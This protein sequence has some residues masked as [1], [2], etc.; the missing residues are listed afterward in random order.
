VTSAG[1]SPR[2]VFTL[3]KEARD[4][5]GPPAP[6]LVSGPLAPQ[7]ARALADGGDAALV[8]TAGDPGHSS[9]VI[10]VLAGAPSVE[11]LALLRV[12]AR[13]GI[14]AVAVQT[15]DGPAAIRYVLPEDVVECPAGQCLRC[16]RRRLAG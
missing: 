4:G 16:G 6:I 5:S 9:A 2:A 7:L 11:Q 12:A 14:P 10:C 13:A 3:V 1:I 15:G 8:R